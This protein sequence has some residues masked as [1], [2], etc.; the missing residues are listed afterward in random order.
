MISAIVILKTQFCCAQMTS[1]EL[2]SL[3]SL[4]FMVEMISPEKIVH[5]KLTCNNDQ[6]SLTADNNMREYDA[7]ELKELFDGKYISLDKG[8]QSAIDFLLIKKYS[9][10]EYII[11]KQNDLWAITLFTCHI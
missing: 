2:Q 4:K 3:A 9:C 10:T 1:E 8:L 5:G 6:W 11:Q 7:M